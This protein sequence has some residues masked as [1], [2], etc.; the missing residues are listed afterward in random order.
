MFLHMLLWALG[1]C[2][3]LLGIVATLHDLLRNR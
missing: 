2:A 1:F 3:V